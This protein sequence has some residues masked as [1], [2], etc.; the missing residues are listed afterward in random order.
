MTISYIQFLFG[1]ILK[2]YGFT[3]RQKNV[4]NSISMNE[5]CV[6]NDEFVQE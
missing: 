1:F 5:I 2:G 4:R 3:L 6:Y